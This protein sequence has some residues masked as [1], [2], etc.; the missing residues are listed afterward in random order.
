MSSMAENV[1]AAGVDIRP[2]MLEKRTVEGPGTSTKQASTRP[3]TYDDLND[4]EKIRKECDIR[5]T[6]IVLQGLPPDVYCNTPKNVS[7]RKY[8]RGRYF[9]I[10]QHKIQENDL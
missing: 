10:Q 8:I 6:N 1:I 9:I 7:Q 3:R 5:E 2:P 4:K